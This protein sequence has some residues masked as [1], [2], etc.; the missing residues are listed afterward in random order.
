MIDTCKLLPNRDYERELILRTNCSPETYTIQL[1][2]NTGKRFRLGFT[3]IFR[4]FSFSLVFYLFGWFSY[5]II[6]SGFIAGL[7]FFSFLTL[8]PLFWIGSKMFKPFYCSLG[9]EDKPAQFLG[10]LTLVLQINLAGW[11]WIIHEF[12]FLKIPKDFSFTSEVRQFF[13]LL[14]LQLVLL[15][16]N[17]LLMTKVFNRIK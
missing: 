6:A 12:I 11:F 14:G 7:N 10:F 3:E 4:L 13:W 15:L 17:L 2:I 5:F 16:L 8:F 1:F 9:F